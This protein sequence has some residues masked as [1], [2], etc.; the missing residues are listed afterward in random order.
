MHAAPFYLLA[1]QSDPAE[2]GN[3]RMCFYR[4]DSNLT[5]TSYLRTMKCANRIFSLSNGGV[6]LNVTLDF[7][8]V[9]HYI[10]CT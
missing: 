2:L 6:A 5:D 1:R 7:Y 8:K 10:Y 9:S 3:S 4:G